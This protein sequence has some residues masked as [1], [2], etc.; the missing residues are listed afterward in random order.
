MSV[1]AF[2]KCVEKLPEGANLVFSGLVEPFL[3]P[4]CMEMIKLGIEMGEALNRNI[5]L[6]DG[7][8]LLC[9]MDFGIKHVLGNLLTQSYEEICNGK[10]LTMIKEGMNGNEK[11]D[12]L[13]RRCTHA[14]VL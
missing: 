7:T 13:C 8:V 2:Q 1:D 4:D 12:I 14:C 5:L 10:E 11:I 6:P 9:C 3:N